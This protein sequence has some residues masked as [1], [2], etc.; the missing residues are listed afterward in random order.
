[1]VQVYS[2]TDCLKKVIIHQPDYGIEQI[3]PEI[4][5]ELL[6]DDIVF[7]YPKW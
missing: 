1:M 7:F 6:Y 3:T 5:E 4:A 2:E